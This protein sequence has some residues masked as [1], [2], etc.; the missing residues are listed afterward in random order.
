MV[1]FLIIKSN[2]DNIGKYVTWA[3]KNILWMVNTQ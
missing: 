1:N 3:Y 2:N